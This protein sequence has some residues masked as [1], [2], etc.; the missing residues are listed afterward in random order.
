M[1]VR[2]IPLEVRVG[3]DAVLT[4]AGLQQALSWL[5]LLFSLSRVRPVAASRGQQSCESRDATAGLR[6]G[7]EGGEV[8][9][10]EGREERADRGGGLRAMKQQKRL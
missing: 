10:K 1:F 2:F 9:K 7:G 8:G 5:V 3:G 6:D 4:P